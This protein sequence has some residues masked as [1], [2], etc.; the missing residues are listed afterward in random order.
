MKDQG[1]VEILEGGELKQKLIIFL[2]AKLLPLIR[3]NLVE[4]TAIRVIWNL[5]QNRG[6]WVGIRYRHTTSI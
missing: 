5:L 1:K 3:I 6:K 2:N 4:K